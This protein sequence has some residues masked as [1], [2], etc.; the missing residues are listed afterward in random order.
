MAE[1]K[2]ISLDKDKLAESMRRL[3]SMPEWADFVK[4]V[5]GTVVVLHEKQAVLHLSRNRVEEAKL[6]AMIVD[7][8]FE[9]IEE[10]DSIV[11]QHDQ[12]KGL[13]ERIGRFCALCGQVVAQ[14]ISAFKAGK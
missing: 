11:E 10:P 7:G 2:I 6:Q 3:K 5:E 8:L 14:K 12:E 4:H 13:M 9:A 1:N